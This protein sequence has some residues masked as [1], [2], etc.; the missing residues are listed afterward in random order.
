MKSINNVIIEGLG[1]EN[2]RYTVLHGLTENS[3][4]LNIKKMIFN[5]FNIPTDI[6]Y[7]IFISLIT[8]QFTMK[9]LLL[10]FVFIISMSINAQKDESRFVYELKFE[11]NPNASVTD[12]SASVVSPNTVNF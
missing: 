1:C 10:L 6:Y 12:A 2:L 4:I 11:V 8:N 9:N 3:T 5:R 7:F